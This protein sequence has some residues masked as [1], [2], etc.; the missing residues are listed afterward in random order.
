MKKFTAFIMMFA[1]ALSVS[2]QATSDENGGQT[3]RK[4]LFERKSKTIDPKYMQGAV[5]EANGKVTWSKTYNVEGQNA[6]QVYDK[7]LAYFSNLVKSENQTE[8]SSVVGVDRVGHKILVRSQEWL[9]FSDKALSLDK[10]KMNYAVSVECSDGAC[11]VLITNISYN[12]EEDRPTAAHYTA[13][14]MISDKVAFNK[15]GT[16]FVKG[17]TRKFRIGTIDRME[18][19]FKSLGMALKTSL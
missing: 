9:V 17:G 4:A 7:A 11:K 19:I 12:Y 6:E 16:G 2:A 14:E 15:K 1:I 5:P 10:T 18:W 8:K 13:E 3:Q